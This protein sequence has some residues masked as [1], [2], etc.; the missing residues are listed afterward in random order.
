MNSIRG[1]LLLSGIVLLSVP[2]NHAFGGFLK[3]ATNV[4]NLV[5]GGN[6]KDNPAKALELAR[7]VDDMSKLSI[8]ERISV[9]QSGIALD[10]AM[11]SA[12]A[13]HQS[14]SSHMKPKEQERA[15]NQFLK[16]NPQAQQQFQTINAEWSLLSPEERQARI[17]AATAIAKNISEDKNH[18]IKTAAQAQVMQHVMKDVKSM[19]PEERKAYLQE[20]RAR[21]QNQ[22]NK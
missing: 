10:S 21:R 17:Q 16:Q 2:Q 11:S 3:K 7:Q 22:N 9:F 4:Q 19:S 12:F 6:L 14:K 18:G 8:Q 20:L 5:G 1:I 13:A 15:F